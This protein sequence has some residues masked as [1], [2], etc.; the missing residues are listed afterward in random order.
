MGGNSSKLEAN[1]VEEL[2]LLTYL[3]KNEVKQ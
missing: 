2:A 3:T 1:Y